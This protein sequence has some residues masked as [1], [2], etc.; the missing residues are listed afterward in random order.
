MT[1]MPARKR[2]SIAWIVA[3]VAVGLLAV[4]VGVGVVLFSRFV[5]TEDADAT[6]AAREFEVVRARLAGQVPLLELRGAEPP[7]FHRDQVSTR[8][9][10]SLHALVY[11]PRDESLRRFNIPVAALRVISVGGSIRL[12]DFGMP[13]DE[14]GRLTLKD[15]EEHGPGLIV[16]AYGGSVAPI[17]A[18][19]ALFGTSTSNA[20]V[21]MWTE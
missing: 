6:S 10:T 7:V 14:R 3:G 1:D 4:V 21:L 8:G 12:I 20:Q 11:S 18:G 5:Q 9:I 19:D 16:D 17:A 13:G 15:L 2:W